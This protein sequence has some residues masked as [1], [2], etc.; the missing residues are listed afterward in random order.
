MRYEISTRDGM[1]Y[2]DDLDTA[3]RVARRLAEAL[4]PHHST[5]HVW[6]TEEYRTNRDGNPIPVYRS[7]DTY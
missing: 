1:V 7:T 4:A 6:D 5:V 3:L 2:S